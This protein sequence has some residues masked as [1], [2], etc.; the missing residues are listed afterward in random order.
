MFEF[1]FC[2]DWGWC[3]ATKCLKLPKLMLFYQN[4]CENSANIV[5]VYSCLSSFSIQENKNKNSSSKKNR[6]EDNCY[7]SYLWRLWNAL[8]YP[9]ILHRKHIYIFQRNAYTYALA[10]VSKWSV[11]L[12]YVQLS[13]RREYKSVDKCFLSTLQNTSNRNCKRSRSKKKEL[14]I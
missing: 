1:P 2:F 5:S 14:E 11:M 10:D 3:K 6:K 12:I 9:F 4:K 13:S 8:F 7:C